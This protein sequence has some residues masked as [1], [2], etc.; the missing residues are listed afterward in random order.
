MILRLGGVDLNPSMVWTD[1]FHSHQVA[2]TVNRTVGGRAV[3]FSTPLKAGQKITLE[4]TAE[5]GWLSYETVQ[6]LKDMASRVGGIF[7]FEIGSLGK[8]EAFSVMFRHNE[9]PA[10]EFEPLVHRAAH[11]ASDYFKGKIKLLT[12]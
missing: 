6:V 3:V 8:L 11:E 1:R 2:Q 12:I 5:S 4:A 10:I 7:Q 9:P